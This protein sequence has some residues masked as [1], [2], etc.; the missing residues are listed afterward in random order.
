[1]NLDDLNFNTDWYS[2]VVSFFLHYEKLPQLRNTF[3]LPKDN[4]FVISLLFAQT[5]NNNI[6]PLVSSFLPPLDLQSQAP[7]I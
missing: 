1:M 7:V 5:K 2:S 6:L 4:N 3:G